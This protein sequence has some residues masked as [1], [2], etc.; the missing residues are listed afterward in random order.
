MI[1]D[2]IK[3]RRQLIHICDQLRREGKIIGFTS[4][5][6]DILHA[7]HVDY[8]EKTKSQCDKLIV[9]INTDAS[10]RKYKGSD[11]PIIFEKHRL[12]TLAALESVDY[13][14]LFEERRN[15]QNIRW[16]QPHIYFKAGDY[17][18][19][20]LTSK[21]IVEQIGGEVRLIPIKEEISTTEIIDRIITLTGSGDHF[22]EEQEKTVHLK[23]KPPK[24]KPAIF[25]DRD[26]T[27]NREIGYVSEPEKFELLP[28]TLEGMKKLQD[29][30][31]RLVIVT[32]QGGI[33]L[34]YF[35]KEDFYQVNKKMLTEVSKAG[36]TIDKIYFC[37]HSKAE[38]C[39]CR[40]PEIGLVIR[41]KEEL[42]IDLTHSY[43]IGDSVADIET[44][45]NSGMKTILIE[46]EL[47]PDPMSL[48]TKPDFVV[49]DLLTSAEIILKQE[50]EIT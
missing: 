42:N 18:A 11:S 19:S 24:M 16:L 1:N 9:G 23:R 6:F 34:G 44:G 15:A 38:R 45:S 33:G 12:K 27:I 21:E 22:V 36:I 47:V 7:G 39:P 46:S 41:A 4:G 20:Q 50:R 43:F 26:G 30:G 3:T 17:L 2:K 10:I 32:N 29:M 35:T 14:F 5:A 31:Y 48:E 49:K 28:N 25:F 37:P 13:V 40:K 8:L